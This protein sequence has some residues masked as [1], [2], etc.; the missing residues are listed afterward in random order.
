M[1]GKN[2]TENPNARAFVDYKGSTT[3]G[4]WLHLSEKAFLNLEIDMY[5]LLKI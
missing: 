1:S 5:N 4:W 2:A 3:D